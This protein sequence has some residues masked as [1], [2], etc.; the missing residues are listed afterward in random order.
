MQETPGFQFGKFSGLHDKN[1]DKIE[2]VMKYDYLKEF[3]KDNI[4]NRTEHNLKHHYLQK[5]DW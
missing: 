4:T 1:A 5:R 3:L 2:D